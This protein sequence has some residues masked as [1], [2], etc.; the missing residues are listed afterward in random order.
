MRFS[1]TLDRT[2]R[3]STS[4]TLAAAAV[5]A[6]V[7]L[8]V[9]RAPSAALL[10][11]AVVVI[12]AVVF[13]YAPRAIALTDRELRIDRYLAPPVVLNVNDVPRVDEAP[14]RLGVRLFGSGGYFGCYGL[15]R[16]RELGPFWAYVTRNGPA[17]VIR[18]RHGRPLVVVP[19]DAEG[20]RQAVAD[21]LRR[22][23]R[24]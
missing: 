5:G 11:A 1:M 10:L 21:W 15:F 14:L 2:Q 6:V 3:I 8:R 18:P 17:F 19:D 23:T 9:V 16:S 24:V 20:F 7:L 13:A 12:L 22:R 4:L